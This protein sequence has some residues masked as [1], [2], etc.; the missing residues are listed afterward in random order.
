[1]PA[2]HWLYAVFVVPHRHS[3]LPAAPGPACFAECFAGHRARLRRTRKLRLRRRGI[4]FGYPSTLA[5]ASVEL[6]ARSSGAVSWRTITDAAG[7][8]G[9]IA[10]ETVENLH[11]GFAVND[12]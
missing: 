4:R 9:E 1:M 10:I 6:D 3:V 7:A 12:P 11:S 5:K 2:E 8:V